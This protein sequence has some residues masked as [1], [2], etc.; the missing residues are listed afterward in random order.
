V[1]VGRAGGLGVEQVPHLHFDFPLGKGILSDSSLSP[2]LRMFCYKYFC[3]GEDDSNADVTVCVLLLH[4]NCFYIYIFFLLL[5]FVCS[6]PSRVQ[7][8]QLQSPGTHSR[9]PRSPGTPIPPLPV[10][11][12]PRP[13]PCLAGLGAAD[14]TWR[15]P[16]R[17]QPFA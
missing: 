3:F 5:L 12:C 16:A 7:I 15:L 2:Q 6:L 4:T 14:A 17:F 11:L 1:T 9:Q 13:L 8:S 10:A